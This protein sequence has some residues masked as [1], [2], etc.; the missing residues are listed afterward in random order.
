M[1]H[2]DE[3]MK[4]IAAVTSGAALGFITNNVPGM[5][6]GA[7]FGN[8]VYLSRMAKEFKYDQVGYSAPFPTKQKLISNGGPLK[9]Q[10][11]SFISRRTYQHR[12]AP[13]VNSKAYKYAKK[14]RQSVGAQLYGPSKENSRNYNPWSNYSQQYGFF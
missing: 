10:S 7:E 9:H 3:A 1:Y 14:H 4:R 2:L 6:A 13:Y 8:E 5:V 12:K 11:S